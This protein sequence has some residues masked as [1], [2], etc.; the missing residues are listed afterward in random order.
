ME[1][2]WLL[3]WALQKFAIGLVETS[4]RE[5]VLAWVVVT[6]SLEPWHLDKVSLLKRSGEPLLSLDMES[7]A[8]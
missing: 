1:A 6:L 5:D 3:Y 4:S 7:L 8:S 2:S